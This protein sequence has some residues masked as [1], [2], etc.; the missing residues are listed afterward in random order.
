MIVQILF[1]ILKSLTEVKVWMDN[2][3][4]LKENL[5]ILSETLLIQKW[6]SKFIVRCIGGI[7]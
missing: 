6:Y 2:I 1:R 7:F 4:Q 5:F 3:H